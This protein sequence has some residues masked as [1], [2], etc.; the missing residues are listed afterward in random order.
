[1]PAQLEGSVVVLTG[2]SSGIARA[3]AVAFAQRGASVVLA[4]RSES[5]LQE[6]AEE[7]RR[8]GGQALVVPTDVADEQAVQ[9][10]ARRAQGQFGRIDVWVN[11]A[12][13]MVYGLFEDTPAAAFRQVIE[14][15]LMGQVH[16]ARAVLPYFREQRQGVMINVAS[17]WGSV[18]SPYVTP[19][20]VSKF[21]V[22]SFSECLQEGLRLERG[23]HD[24]HVCTILPQSVDTPIFR[25]SGNYTERTPRPVPLVVDPQRVVRAI[26]R[27]VDHP[28]RQR[29]VG[30]WGRLLELGHGM[31]PGFYSRL[32]PTVMNYG[33]FSGKPATPGPGN[34]FES[35]PEWNQVEG[36]WIRPKRRIAAAVAAG[37][38][39]AAAA[40][41][42]THRARKAA[43][44]G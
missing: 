3:A 17:V 19:Y 8:V 42:A 12:G 25:H 44:K 40:G 29:T 32:V 11:A 21:G 24:I 10:L 41:A 37:T 14:T 22:R 34:V 16:G 9:E 23:G 39:L 38:T 26:L 36:G 31:L 27:T 33:A 20:V 1:M 18:T 35:M 6:A 5:S 15:N 7:C 28:R 30:W 4:A 43:G 13:V 2:A